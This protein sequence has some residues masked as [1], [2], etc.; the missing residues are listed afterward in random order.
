MSIVFDDPEQ[1]RL[2]LQNN[3]DYQVT[4]AN[5]T[6]KIKELLSKK[7]KSKEHEVFEDF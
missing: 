7:K 3:F 4:K 5:M 2:K 1:K 6:E